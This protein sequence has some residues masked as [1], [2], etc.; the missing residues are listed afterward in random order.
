MYLR[1]LP[2]H[3]QDWISNHTRGRRHAGLSAADF[4]SNGVRVQF[5]DG[6]YALFRYAFVVHDDDRG[7]VAV[8]TEHCGYY[9][10]KQQAV[11]CSEVS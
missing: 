10:F 5:A 3:W 1:S 9:V 2:A 4:P 11:S 8:F 6:S 7:E